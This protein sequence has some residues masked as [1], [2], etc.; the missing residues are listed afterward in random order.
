MEKIEQFMNPPQKEWEVETT[1]SSGPG[2]QNVNKVESKVRVT[3]N[4]LASRELSEDEKSRL[5]KAFP[6]GRIEVTSQETPSQHRN[7]DDAKRKIFEKRDATLTPRKERI[8]TTTPHSA[9]ERRLDEKRRGA[10][11]KL[12]RQNKNR[13]DTWE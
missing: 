6:E 8:P 2:G 5:L 12:S 1:R 11:K 7:R 3:W 13:R 10:E 9:K 4:F